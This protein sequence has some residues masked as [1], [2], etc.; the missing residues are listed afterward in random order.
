[1]QPSCSLFEERALRDT[2]RETIRPGGLRLTD[3]AMALCNLPACSRI[4]D[5]GCG[6]GASVVYLKN[7]YGLN[8]FGL[9]VSAA[10]LEEGRKRYPDV[11][12]IRAA[13]ESLPVGD[14][15]LDAVL[16]ECVLSL[17]AD[18]G[19]VLREF[20]RVLLDGGRLVITDIYLRSSEKPGGLGHLPVRSCLTGAMVQSEIEARVK[21]SGFRILLW[22]DHTSFLKE[23]AVRLIFTHGSMRDFWGQ[24]CKKQDLG[25]IESAVQHARPGYY[26]LI[27]ER[28]AA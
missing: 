23:M 17:T 11:H 27:A 10:L 25:G 21:Q 18:P 16:C 15:K 20:H 3:R 13:A 22:E 6:V 8:A 7:G 26:L 1:V 9:D 2:T 14:G 24:F 28:G 5:V 12:L 19:V 4:L